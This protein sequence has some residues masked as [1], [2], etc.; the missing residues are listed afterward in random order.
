MGC[1]RHVLQPH[2]NAS[3]IAMHHRLQLAAESVAPENNTNEVRRHALSTSEA[4]RDA[5]TVANCSSLFVEAGNMW[6]RQES[7]AKNNFSK[8]ALRPH[9]LRNSVHDKA[10]VDNYPW[11]PPETLTRVFSISPTQGHKFSS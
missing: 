2:S 4:M 3:T 6:G 10:I 1:P 5:V 8:K 11:D 7:A 9:Q